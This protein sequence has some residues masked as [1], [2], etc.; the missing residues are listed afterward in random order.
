MNREENKRQDIEQRK[1]QAFSQVIQI[2]ENIIKV[3][4][5]GREFILWHLIEKQLNMVYQKS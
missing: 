5:D 2:K 4:K 1:Q 3:L